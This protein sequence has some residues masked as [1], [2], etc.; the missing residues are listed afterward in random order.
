MLMRH[1]STMVPNMILLV[2]MVLLTVMLLVIVILVFLSHIHV[3][4][5]LMSSPVH[6]HVLS[7]LVTLI[8]QSICIVV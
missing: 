5:A 8:V 3:H 1:L 2:M 4:V 7:L 6:H